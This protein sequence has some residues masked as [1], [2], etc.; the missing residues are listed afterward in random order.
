MGTSRKP[1]GSAADR[2]LSAAPGS[3]LPCRLLLHHAPRLAGQDPGYHRRTDIPRH[4]SP[5]DSHAC[6]P[7]GPHHAAGLRRVRRRRGPAVRRFGQRWGDPGRPGSARHPG[8]SRTVCPSLTAELR[9]RVRDTARPPRAAPSRVCSTI[10]FS[11]EPNNDRDTS[12]AHTL[13]NG[14]ALAACLGPPGVP[15]AET[16]PAASPPERPPTPTPREAA[17]RSTP[18]SKRHAEV[19]SIPGSA[20]SGLRHS[21]LADGTPPTPSTYTCRTPP[22]RT[23]RTSGAHSRGPCPR[24]YWPTS[25]RSGCFSAWCPAGREAPARATEAPWRCW[26]PSPFP[27]CFRPPP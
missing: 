24:S 26:E 11:R 27:C 4:A 12:A 6:R 19:H 3:C 9:T 18:P 22:G 16:P 2:E 13:L 15:V 8:H 21:C 14:I 10:T 1:S 23:P 20:R 25:P 17:T 7:D 5:P